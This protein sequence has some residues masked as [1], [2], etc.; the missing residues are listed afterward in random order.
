M[1]WLYAVQ[2]PFLPR[3]MVKVFVYCQS[4]HFYN[5]YFINLEKFLVNL[6][7]SDSNLEKRLHCFETSEYSISTISFKN[8]NLFS[9]FYFYFISLFITVYYKSR[10]VGQ[11]IHNIRGSNYHLSNTSFCFMAKIVKNLQPIYL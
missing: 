3:L 8:C 11:P 5:Y 2:T 7:E 1:D 4:T 10:M 6:F 9:T